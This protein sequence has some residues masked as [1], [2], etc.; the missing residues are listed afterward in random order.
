MIHEDTYLMPVEPLEQEV[1]TQEMGTDIEKC[2]QGVFHGSIDY[3]L[4]L[5]ATM[6]S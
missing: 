4:I 2:C 1:D 6:R 5:L 3:F